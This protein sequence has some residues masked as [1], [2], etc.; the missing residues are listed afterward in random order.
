MMM[1]GPATDTAAPDPSSNP[2]PI[3]PPTATIAMAPEPSRRCSFGFS[4]DSVTKENHPTRPPPASRSLHP[5]LHFGHVDACKS[6]LPAPQFPHTMN[7]PHPQQ[8]VQFPCP[9]SPSVS[10]KPTS[11]Y[12]RAR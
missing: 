8:S 1:A 5:E 7:E 12:K 11:I 6:S 10:K 4:A 9:T 3:E 2:V